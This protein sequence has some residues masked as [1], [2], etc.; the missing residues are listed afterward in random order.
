MIGENEKYLATVREIRARILDELKRSNT[1]NAEV[2]SKLGLLPV[3]F[4]VFCSNEL[5]SMNQCFSLAEVLGLTI[6]FTVKS[7]D[8]YK[9]RPGWNYLPY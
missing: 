3:G 8:Q 2:A 1:T 7:P 6:D 9:R 5:W 4:E